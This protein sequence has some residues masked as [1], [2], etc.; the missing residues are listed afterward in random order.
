MFDTDTNKLQVYPS[1]ISYPVYTDATILCDNLYYSSWFEPYS[2][3]YG[4]IGFDIKTH[5]LISYF[6]ITDPYVIIQFG[7]TDTPGVFMILDSYNDTS[8]N[9]FVLEISQLTISGN[10]TSKKEIGILQGSNSNSFNDYYYSSTSW[11]FDQDRNELWGCLLDTQT[12]P[13]QSS[14]LIFDTKSGKLKSNYSYPQQGYNYYAQLTFPSTLKKNDQAENIFYGMMIDGKYLRR[15]WVLLT[16][17]N[18]TNTL[19]LVVLEKKKQYLEGNW[20]V[21][22][23]D[24]G[25][26]NALSEKGANVIDIVNGS[27]K[28]EYDF[29][30]YVNKYTKQMYLTSIVCVV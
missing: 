26:I 3:M 7:C 13:Y 24:F 4:I 30:D 28:A 21:L 15:D 19:S 17:N 6:E 8:I 18:D 23:G 10:K 12:Y 5:T 29:K 11:I 9:Q 22:C 25:Y 20:M 2:T 16:I 14:L 27:L 1:P